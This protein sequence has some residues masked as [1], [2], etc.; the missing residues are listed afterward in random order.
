MIRNEKEKNLYFRFKSTVSIFSI[1]I[2]IIKLLGN[3]SAA[4]YYRLIAFDF[5]ARALGLMLD[6]L[7]E[8]SWEIDEVD[9]RLT[10]ESL[11]EF[12]PPSVFDLI[13]HKYT[14][15]SEKKNANGETLWR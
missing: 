10:Y 3:V 2:I 8:N 11:Q 5:E 12:M 4:G 15:P 7:D 6:F 13:F 14:E 1:I 9:K